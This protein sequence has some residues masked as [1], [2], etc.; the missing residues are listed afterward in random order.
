MDD[1]LGGAQLHRHLA[2]GDLGV[3]AVELPHDALDALGVAGDHHHLP[4]HVH[5]L[6]GL[7]DA[8]VDGER[9]V[10]V[11]PGEVEELRLHP[12]APSGWPR[13]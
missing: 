4:G 10:V 12:L 9:L 3:P 1:G 5:A 8:L 7:V 2:E 13:C 6:E 11:E